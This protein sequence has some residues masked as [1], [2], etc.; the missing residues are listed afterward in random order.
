M[1]QVQSL[2]VVF[3]EIP[4]VGGS[5]GRTSIDKRPVG[6]RRSV[7]S[8]GVFGDQRSDM[9]HHGASTQAVYAYAQE[10]YDWWSA[11][12]GRDFNAGVFGENLTTSNIDLNALVVG[13]KIRIGSVRNFCALARR[14]TMGKEVHRGQSLRCIF[15]GA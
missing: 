7:T 15:W 10:D 2:N 1:A 6:D 13:T 4:D 9:K 5:V 8:D 11:E 14:R 12:L 3:A